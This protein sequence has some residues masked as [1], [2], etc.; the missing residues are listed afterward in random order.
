[1]WLQFI[2]QNIHFGIYIFGA[3]VVW[4]IAWLYADAWRTKRDAKEL[5]KWL[6]FVFLGL[7][8]ICEATVIEQ[9]VL[10]K[11]VFGHFTNGLVIALR[12]AAYAGIIFGNLIDPLQAIPKTEGLVLEEE[13]EPETPTDKKHKAAPLV[14]GGAISLS[15]RIL[16]PLGALTIAALYWRRATTGLERH[17]KPIARGFLL[18]AL[19]D[20]LGIA[21]LLRTTSNP[22]LYSFV[23]A[24]GPAWWLQ[25][26]ILLAGVIIL[27]F[28]T[29]G[30]L[31][32]RFFSQLFMV[33]TGMVVAV[34]LFVSVGF[35]LLLLSNIRANT[36][37]NLQTAV[38]V[39]GYA[40]TSKQAQTMSASQQLAGSSDVRQAVVARDHEKLKTL[41]TNF[42]A[43]NKL[44]GL[45]I[46]NQSG[47]VLLRGEDTDAWGDSLS[48]DIL[49]KRALIGLE[50][51]TV[52]VREGVT[53]PII[54]VRSAAAIKD[55]NGT[56]V[57]GILTSLELSSAFADGI[58]QTTG[59][60]S[61]V[62]A[63]NKLV[64]T[65]LVAPDGKT[66]SVGL[67]INNQKITTAVLDKGQSYTGNI[68]LQQRNM[69]GAFL[70]IKDADNESVGMLAVAEP[71]STI[72]KTA[73][74]SVELTFLFTVALLLLSF[75]PTALIS[76]NLSQQL[77]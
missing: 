13:K 14:L 57:G 17:L 12:L 24:F 35:T 5:F 16:L 44:S 39:L 41:T 62:Y 4:G 71:E 56:I 67:K 51:S 19:S 58:K 69:L 6:G 74:R 72:L 23:S 43:D 18:L 21:I 55:T 48:S 11:S 36:F 38:Q 59:L 63:D 49:V 47:Q 45:I 15:S 37:T 33:L 64:A 53:S 68:K 3:L 20:I 2:A 50:Q 34:F 75:V 70:P 27:G 8:L 66:R 25:H 29:W 31:L 73:G 7:S 1:V 61:S 30:Y 54:S 9:S 76:K 65:T 28:W 22:M 52:T 40:L 32:E 10:G 42:L 46:T 77:E 60:Q 26:L